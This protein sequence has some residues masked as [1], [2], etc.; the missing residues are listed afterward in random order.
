MSY[1]EPSRPSTVGMPNRSAQEIRRDVEVQR[2]ELGR[3]V[4]T[5]R[6]RVAELTDW[7]R[8]IR[9]HRRELIAG[10]AIAGFVVGGIIAL[11][12]RR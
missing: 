4:E 8:Q 2:E 5:L 10:A 9:E 3:S 11:R 12:R 7:R 1:P 6:A